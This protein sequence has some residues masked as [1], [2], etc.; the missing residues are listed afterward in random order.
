MPQQQHTYLRTHTLAGR[1]LAFGLTREGDALLTR[2]RGTRALRSSKQLVKE[3]RLRVTLLA[4]A[5][6]AALAQHRVEGAVSIQVLRGRAALQVADGERPL[7]AGDLVSLT[8]GVGHSLS[9]RA[10]SVVLITLSPD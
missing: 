7:K 3:P 10:D 4:L 8:S 6:G 1:A 9:A 5:K 2:A